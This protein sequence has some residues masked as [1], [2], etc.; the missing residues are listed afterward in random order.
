MLKSHLCKKT[1]DS[2]IFQWEKKKRGGLGEWVNLKRG[3]KKR[4]ST[5]ETETRQSAIDPL[6]S[7]IVSKGAKKSRVDVTKCQEKG[8]DIFSTDR[9]I[10]Q[11]GKFIS[12]GLTK[13]RSA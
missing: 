8:G 11:A 3:R 4:L 6:G 1:D 9:S 10:G 5:R 2:N 7:E 12:L 13:R